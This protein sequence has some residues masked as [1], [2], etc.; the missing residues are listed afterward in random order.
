MIAKRARVHN[1]ELSK[2]LH[3]EHADLKMDA[4]QLEKRRVDLM[5]IRAQDDG[6]PA[7]NVKAKNDL[8]M[9]QHTKHFLKS[10]VNML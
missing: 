4:L 9:H 7:A 6:K 8:V 10:C 2:S 3:L 1:R 5:A